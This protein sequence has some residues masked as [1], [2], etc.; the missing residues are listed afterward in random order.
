MARVCEKWFPVGSYSGQSQVGFH[1]DDILKNNLDIL[2]KNIVHDWDFTIIVS[3]GGE[4]RVGKSRLAFQIA[5]YWTYQM[6]EVHKIDVPLA[7]KL[8]CVFN[9]TELIEKGNYLGAHHKYACL[10]FDE[11]G[12]DLEGRKVM[13]SVT[14]NV[15][16][17]FR[18]CGQYN[19]LN[20][21]VIPE[22]FDLPKSIAISRSTLLIDVY[23]LHTKDNLIDRGHFK[24]YS[25]HNKKQLYR[26]GKR[27]LDYKA[28]GADWNKGSFGNMF[29]LDV[30]EYKQMK[31]EALKKREKQKKNRFIIV[32]DVMFYLYYKVTHKTSGEVSD[33]I[34]KLT[35]IRL[36]HESISKPVTYYLNKENSSSNDEEEEETDD[37]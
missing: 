19:L 27:E 25:P 2:I 31:I 35:K 29:P 24:L 18:E 9:G 17:Y 30:E 10:L 11:A 20:I 13:H 14:Q 23:T 3:G 8:N 22:F 26:L 32:R 5:C 34:K 7:L 36:D 12:A 28:W 16:D 33:E 37:A 6:M 21:L 15:L 1:M 4:V